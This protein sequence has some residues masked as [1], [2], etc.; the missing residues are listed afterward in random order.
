MKDRFYKRE[1]ASIK[2]SDVFCSL[3]TFTAAS[4]VCVFLCD[5]LIKLKYEN[6]K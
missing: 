2:C 4:V 3:F 1:S 6:K 5:K